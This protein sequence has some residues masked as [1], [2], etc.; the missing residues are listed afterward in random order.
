MSGRGSRG[1]LEPFVKLR[2]IRR[3]EQRGGPRRNGGG[4]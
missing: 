4:E 1:V 2:R 3:E